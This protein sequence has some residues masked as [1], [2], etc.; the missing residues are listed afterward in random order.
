MELQPHLETHSR[1]PYVSAPK[2][3]F[4]NAADVQTR[5]DNA[6]NDVFAFRVAP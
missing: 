6:N 3:M 5:H 1:S 2:M 4:G